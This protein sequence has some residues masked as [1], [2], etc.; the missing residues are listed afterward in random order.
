MTP[1]R[2]AE[3]SVLNN[4][5]SLS[6][7]LLFKCL[8]HIR[9]WIWQ[10]K[11]WKGELSFAATYSGYLMRNGPNQQWERILQHNSSSPT[12]STTYRIQL[13]FA[14]VHCLEPG[15][16]EVIRSMNPYLTQQ[17]PHTATSSAEIK[18]CLI[19]WLSIPRKKYIYWPDHLVSLTW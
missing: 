13:T 7:H 15:R 10:A 2:V 16:E 9:D 18:K 3:T 17:T 14:L 12:L 4:S 1:S 11:R 5:F 6:N 19:P 8:A